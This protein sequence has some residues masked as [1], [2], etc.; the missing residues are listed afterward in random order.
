M[1]EHALFLEAGFTPKDKPLIMEAEKYQNEF[2]VILE[3]AIHLSN[4]IV[5]PEIITS[6]EL[7][8]N[9]TIKAEQKTSTLTGIP[10]DTNVTVLEANLT[11]GRSEN[12]TEEMVNYVRPINKRARFLL[13]NFITYQKQILDNVLTCQ[14]FTYNYPLMID[15]LIEEAKLYLAYMN[16]LENNQTIEGDKE[17]QRRFWNEIM[18]EHALFIRGLMDP[19]E[20]KVIHEANEFAKRYQELMQEMRNL[21]INFNHDNKKDE[22]LTEKFKAFNQ[23]GT[24][25]IV[26]CQIRSIIVPLLADHVL[27]EANH[28]L[29]ILKEK[30]LMK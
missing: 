17:G 9:Y 26:E 28:Y 11:S 29:R 22:E 14:I 18:M 12:I 13:E 5:S 7:I 15:H 27:R 30:N 21:G 16:R 4:N 10:I 3:Q 8:T 24:K 20:S 25:G 1:K 19:S 23:T 2:K 6:Q